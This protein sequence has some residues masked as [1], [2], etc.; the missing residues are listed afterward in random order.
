MAEREWLRTL[1]RWLLTPVIQALK[2][3]YQA[4]AFTLGLL[5]LAI[6]AERQRRRRRGS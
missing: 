3:P 4:S 1:T 6:L 5:S 2:Y